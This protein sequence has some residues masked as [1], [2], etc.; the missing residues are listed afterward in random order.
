MD[1]LH[2]PLKRNFMC[3]FLHLRGLSWLCKNSKGDPFF[4]NGKSSLSSLFLI[5]S[6]ELSYCCWNPPR[7]LLCTSRL[8]TSLVETIT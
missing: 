5:P 8:S 3:F 7:L 2:G 1:L 6:S 4:V